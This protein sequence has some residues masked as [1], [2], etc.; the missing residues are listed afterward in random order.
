[1]ARSSPAEALRVIAIQ[2]LG[3]PDPRFATPDPGSATPDARSATPDPRSATPDA[4]SAT[5][6]RPA[7]AN[8][9]A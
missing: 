2:P 9:D 7:V 3:A 4:R 8:L 1:M 6:Q 5:H